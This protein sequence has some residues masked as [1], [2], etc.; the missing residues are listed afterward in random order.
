MHLLKSDKKNGA[1]QTN[2]YFNYKYT[3]INVAHLQLE[4]AT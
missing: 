3:T 2:Q 1:L 4:L